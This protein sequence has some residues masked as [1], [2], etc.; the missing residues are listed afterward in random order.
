MSSDRGPSQGRRQPPPSINGRPGLACF[1]REANGVT[2]S[3]T[4]VTP[5]FANP[6]KSAGGVAKRWSATGS[7]S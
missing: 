5:A 3:S 4:A 1:E 2:G 7:Q 6:S